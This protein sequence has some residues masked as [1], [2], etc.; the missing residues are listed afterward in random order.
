MA[1]KIYKNSLPF[2]FLIIY[3]FLHSVNAANSPCSPPNETTVCLVVVPK[4]VL[5]ETSAD[6]ISNLLLKF[7]A[8]FAFHFFTI[9]KLNRFAGASGQSSQTEYNSQACSISLVLSQTLHKKN[10]SHLSSEGD[11][12]FPSFI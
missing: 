4:A 3:V 11:A 12:E 7:N 9:P 6:G 2:F 10:I 1:P 5:D 8:P